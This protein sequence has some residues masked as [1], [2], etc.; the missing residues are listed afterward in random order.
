MRLRFWGDVDEVDVDRIDIDLPASVYLDAFPDQEFASSVS[1]I[2]PAAKLTLTGGT[3][4][5]V[6]LDLGDTPREVLIGMKGDVTIEIEVVED[7]VVVPIEALFDEDD[8]TFVYVVDD[9]R[10]RRER[11]EV[12]TLTETDVEIISGVGTG[13]TVA[14][15]GTAEFV[16]DLS[17]AIP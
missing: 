7:V 14:L 12:G 17:V 11:V 8:G 3:I 2:A 10:L 1:R 6:S 15:S 16:D 5:P 13:E 4:F 9:G